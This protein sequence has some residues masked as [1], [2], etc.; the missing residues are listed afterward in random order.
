[1]VVNGKYR[2]KGNSFENIL[3]NTSAM[4]AR[5]RAQASAAR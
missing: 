2:I 1:M 3:E 4:V 5:E